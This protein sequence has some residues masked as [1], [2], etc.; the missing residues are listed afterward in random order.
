M[1]DLM[2]YVHEHELV[3]GD[4]GTHFTTYKVNIISFMLGYYN[5]K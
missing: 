1:K 5:L 3:E 2:N 4:H